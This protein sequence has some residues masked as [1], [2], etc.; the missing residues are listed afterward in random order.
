M[1]V[2]NGN[3]NALRGNVRPLRGNDHAVFYTAP[4][5]QWLVF[6]FF[7]FSAN[8]GNDIIHHFRPTFK[9]FSGAAD[10]LI[11][12]GKRFSNAELRKREQRGYI[13]LQRTI[14]FYRDKAA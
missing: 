7:L 12:A 4:N 5:F 1:A 8:V 3:T 10:R 6:A 13:A 9:S 2:G 11:G 14:G